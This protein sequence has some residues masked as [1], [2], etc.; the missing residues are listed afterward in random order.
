MNEAMYKPLKKILLHDDFDNG[1]NGWCPLTPNLSGDAFEYFESQK[2]YKLWGG[3]MLS[4]ASFQFLGT[5]GSMDGLYCMKLATRPVAGEPTR[6][7]V[8]G[9]MAHAIK[10]MTVANQG[11]VKVETWYS[12][13]PEQDRHG[14]GE[15]DVR[16]FGFFCDIQDDKYRY[17]WGA[18]Y[19]NAA[20]GKMVGKWEYFRAAPGRDEDW[21]D[22]G[23]SAVGEP[24]GSQKVYLSRG[25]DSQWLGKRFADGT[26][27]GYTDVP[28]GAQALCYNETP[29]KINWHYFS[30][31]FD[32]RKRE[33][34]D[35]QSVDKK[36]DLKGCKPTLVPAFPRIRQLLNPVFFIETD[37]NRRAF[38]FVDSVVMSMDDA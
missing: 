24:G 13:K 34:V 14:L 2:R 9:S 3:P 1:L 30:M 37:A 29:D 4:N 36:F 32:L 22:M 12:Y 7:P 6:Q 35:M 19:L 31:S 33:Y 17:F 16:A 26:A 18:R 11:L 15:S 8:P 23:Q 27:D 28:G 21:G 25:I 38:L 10:R 20:A 5:H